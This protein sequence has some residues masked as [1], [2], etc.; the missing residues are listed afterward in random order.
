MRAWLCLLALACAEKR[1][2]PVRFLDAKRDG[3]QFL[4]YKSATS[5]SFVDPKGKPCES[6]GSMLGWESP[7]NASD[8]ICTHDTLYDGLNPATLEMRWTGTVPKDGAYE[9]DT[10]GAGLEVGG[11]VVTRGSWFGDSFSTAKLVVEVR[12]PHC[13][14]SWSMPI[15]SAFAQGPFTRAAPF[16][17]TQTIPPLSLP[18]CKAGDA[19]DVRAMLVGHANRGHIDIESFGFPAARGPE[20]DRIFGVLPLKDADAVSKDH[21]CTTWQGNF[22]VEAEQR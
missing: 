22:C 3:V 2:A 8:P 19:L 18:D 1:A 13:S 12:S 14:V 21:K 9:L 16:A 4:S 17:S 7:P 5:S 10:F 20:A 6:A 11:T 15:A